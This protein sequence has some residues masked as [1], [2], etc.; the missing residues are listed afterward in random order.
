VLFLRLP[1]LAIDELL[2]CGGKS[3]LVFVQ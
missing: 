1:T 2:Y 3:L